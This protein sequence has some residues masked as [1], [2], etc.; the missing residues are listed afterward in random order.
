MDDNHYYQLNGKS[1][2]ENYRHYKNKKA[3]E[4]LNQILNRK[5]LEKQIADTVEPVLNDLLSTFGKSGKGNN[6]SFKFGL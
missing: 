3:Y 2:E 4:F 6:I 1:A 5:Q